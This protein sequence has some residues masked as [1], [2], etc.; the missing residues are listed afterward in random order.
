MLCNLALL[1]LYTALVYSICRRWT[2]RWTATLAGAGCW[3]CS[4]SRT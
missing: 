2:D 1:A 4:G 3:A